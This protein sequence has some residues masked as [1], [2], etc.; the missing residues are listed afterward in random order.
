M[1]W[2]LHPSPSSWAVGPYSPFMV[3]FALAAASHSQPL[4]SPCF[5]EIFLSISQF[6]EL[7]PSLCPLVLR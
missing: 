6:L 1:F 2:G 5:Y 4:L 3:A 7:H